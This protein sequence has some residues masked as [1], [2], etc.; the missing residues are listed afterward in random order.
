MRDAPPSAGNRAP[1]AGNRTPAG[2]GTPAGNHTA[3]G[4]SGTPAAGNHTATGGSGTPAAGNH[5]A[6]G[7]R[8]LRADAA[9]NRQRILQ[10]AEDVFARDGIAVPVDVVAERAGVGIGTLYR[11]FPTKEALFE[12][13]VQLRLDELLAAAAIEPGGD[14]TEAFFSFLEK[15]CEQVSLK[16][17][18][19][20]ALA[21]A[22][23]DLKARCAT[24]V[25][26]LKERVRALHGRAVDS[27]GVRGDVTT[28]EVM[29]LVLGACSQASAPNADGDSSTRRMLRVV[30][31]GL[32]TGR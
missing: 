25:D 7:G 5:T 20:D 22:G 17:D 16:H 12:A 19:F 18:L 30:C 14:A 13:V 31:D 28:D 11:H 23:V 6:T 21:E 2:S 26:A 9:R 15:M 27:G 29:G 10:A 8:P 32:R 4:G 3:T 24:Q 1:T